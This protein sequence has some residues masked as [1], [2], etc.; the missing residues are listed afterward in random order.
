PRF[1]AGRIGIKAGTYAASSDAFDIRITGRSSHGA[2]PYQGIDAIV[3]AAQLI[4]AVQTIVSRNVNAHD[5]AVLSLGRINGGTKRNIVAGEVFIEGTLRTLSEK[6]RDTVIHRLTEMVTDIP[7]SFGARGE[8][9]VRPGAC[10][11]QNDAGMID[12]IRKNGERL[13]GS[14]NVIHEPNPS[15]GVE[16]FAFYLKDIPGAIYSLGTRGETEDTSHPVHTNRFDV[17]ETAMVF[18]TALQV[19]NVLTCP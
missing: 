12:L 16:D 7:R 4:T 17:D 14:E 11:L 1:R 13:L 8:L 2:R 5:R 18:G 9:T 19:M 15:M 3:V 10:L 6:V